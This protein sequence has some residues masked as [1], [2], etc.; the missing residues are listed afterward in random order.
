M[1]GPRR[2]GGGTILLCQGQNASGSSV[3]SAPR[4]SSL[5]AGKQSYR[6]ALGEPS[7]PA[8]QLSAPGSGLGLPRGPTLSAGPSV[9]CCFQLACIKLSP[10]LC[11]EAAVSTPVECSGDNTLVR[12]QTGRLSRHHRPWSQW[13]PPWSRNTY[14]LGGVLSMSIPLC[15][16]GMITHEI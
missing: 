5:Q 14:S 12:S 4:T 15:L 7:A 3:T 10:L 13:A 9:T 2:G 1:L 6:T 16:L 11:S 8:G